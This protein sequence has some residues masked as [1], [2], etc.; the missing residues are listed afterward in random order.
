MSRQTN[1]AYI[2]IKEK[3]LDGTFRP[4]QKLIES[5]LSETIGVSRNTIKKALLMLEKEN[6]IE[7]ENNKGATIKSFTLEE[8]INYL[9]IREV[10]EGL[11]A[12]SAAIHITEAQLEKIEEVFHNMTDCLNENR[13]DEYSILNRE[14]HSIIYQASRNTQ[15]VQLIN[16]IKTQLNRLHLKTIFLPGRNDESYHEHKNILEALKSRDEIA[17]EE[18]IKH[19]VT[20]VRKVIE[21]NYSYLL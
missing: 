13:L 9:E 3:I 15:A 10:L 19:H 5:Q 11:V 18:A 20:N 7:V 16:T 6:L 21:K 2:Y 4:S 12:K 14:F 17:L 8:I 1:N